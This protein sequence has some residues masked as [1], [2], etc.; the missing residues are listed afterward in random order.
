MRNEHYRIRFQMQT[1]G[2]EA[3]VMIYSAIESEKWFE[4]DVTPGDFD[5]AL[6]EARKT[7][8]SRL[9]IRINSPGGDVYS[10][11]A[12]RSM[13]VNARFDEVHVMIEGLC[14]SAATLIATVPGASVTIADGS[15]YMIH[16][17]MTVVW[18]NAGEIEK[19]V[20]HLRKMEGQFQEMYAAR[21]GQSVEQIKDWMDAETWF[22]AKEARDCGFCDDVQESAP[23]AACVSARDM[24]VMT[25]LYRAVPEGIAVQGEEAPVDN[26]SNEAPVAGDSAEIQT[27]EEVRDAMEIKDLNLEQLRAENPALVEQIQQCA[28]DAERQRVDDIDALT[29]PGYEA[30]AAQAK[31]GGTS[32]ME[33]QKQLVAAMREKGNTFLEQRRQETANAQNVAGGDA[34]DLDAKSEDAIDAAAKEIAE[35]AR[36]YSASNNES[37]F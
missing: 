3:E 6:K 13:I 2:D 33:F 23:V 22:T 21:T 32:A 26:V 31:Q 19:T 18:G 7:G 27:K 12:M 16:N 1:S 35:Y 24:A 34:R 25:A 11:I 9:N 4:E 30:M 5:K 8:A 20:D 36:A 15:E 10:A 17:P 37:M 28:I 29:V 14:A